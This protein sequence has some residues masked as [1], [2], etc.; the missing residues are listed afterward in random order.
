MSGVMTNMKHYGSSR[1]RKRPDGNFVTF[2]S[3]S[4]LLDMDV[5]N[6]TQIARYK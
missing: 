5:E 1:N 4:N 2:N 3:M 6:N